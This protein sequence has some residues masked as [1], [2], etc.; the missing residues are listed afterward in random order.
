MVDSLITALVENYE[1]LSKD[2]FECQYVGA[3]PEFV[4]LVRQFLKETFAARWIGRL[5]Q[6]MASYITGFNTLRILLTGVLKKTY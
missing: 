3:R 2:L 4:L 6:M 1:S 5:G